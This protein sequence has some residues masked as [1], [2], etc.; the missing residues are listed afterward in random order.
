MPRRTSRRWWREAAEAV[1]MAPGRSRPAAAPG[2]QLVEEEVRSAWRS[3]SARR[4]SS[5]EASP[6]DSP[7]DLAGR[8]YARRRAPTTW[9]PFARRQPAHRR[10]GRAMRRARASPPTRR[11]RPRR[12]GGGRGLERASVRSC[13]RVPAAAGRCVPGDHGLASRPTWMAA[14][15]GATACRHQ[16]PAFGCLRV[17]EGGADVRGWR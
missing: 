15:R 13:R 8:P 7:I 12:R 11:A 5:V 9:A 14:S 17:W 6:R 10:P 1:V 4:C 16:M 3:A 2:R